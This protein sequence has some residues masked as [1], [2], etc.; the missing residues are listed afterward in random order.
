MSSAIGNAIADSLQL[1]LSYAE[2]LLKDVPAETFARFATP[3][4]HVVT[5]NH[6]AFVYGHLSL[7]PIRIVEALGGD[8]AAIAPPTQFAE[9]FSKD[10]TCQ[11]DP[12]GTVYPP[13]EDVTSSFFQGYRAVLPLLRESDGAVFEQPNPLGGRMAE[14]FPTLGSMHAFYVGGH[15][16]MHLGQVSAW[17]RMQGLGAA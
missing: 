7:Y 4:G 15:I 10:A 8:T 12:D 1:S 11:D 5:S 17:R 2:R 9:V 3:G 13:M 6:P 14:L 16:M